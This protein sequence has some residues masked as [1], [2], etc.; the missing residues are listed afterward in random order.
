MMRFLATAIFALVMAIPAHAAAPNGL[1]RTASG[2]LDVEIKACGAVLCGD[3]ARVLANT[4][5]EAGAGPSKAAPARTGL[6]ILS[7]L[8]AQGELWQGKIFNRENGRTYDCQVGVLDAQQLEVRPF[9]V[10]PLFGRT[11]I[12]RRAP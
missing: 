8:R 10:L 4:S 7:G 5:M 6:R 11:Q 9:I 3:V 1:W 2:N 12:W